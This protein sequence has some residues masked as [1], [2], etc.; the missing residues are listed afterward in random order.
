MTS[1][2]FSPTQPPRIHLSCLVDDQPRFRMHAWNWLVALAALETKV[3]LFIH[4]TPTALSDATKDQFRALGAT[5][6][7][8]LPFDHGP[9]RYCNKIRQLETSEFTDADFVILSDADMIFNNDPAGMVRKDHLRARVVDADNPPRAIWTELFSRAGLSEALARVGNIPLALEPTV[10]TFATNFNGGFYAM[11]G[12]MARALLPL[13]HKYAAFSLSQTDLLGKWLLHSD[14]LGF[15]MAVA[16][17]GFAVDLLPFTANL[18]T[19]LAKQ[20]YAPIAAQDVTA[21]HYH[22]HLDQHGLPLPV[23]VDWIDRLIAKS[24][25]VLNEGRRTGF[26][27]EIFW[28]YRYDQFPELGSGLGSRDAV[29]AHKH[30]LLHP[31]VTMIGTGTILDVGC[32]DL[33]VFGPLPA[34]NYTGIDISEQALMIARSKRPDCE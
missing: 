22:K 2:L 21:L 3:R 20:V 14:Q 12:S 28:D 6:V 25:Q 11:P 16:D 19:H 4:H 15:G 31:F 24:R 26:S 7:E 32:G 34:V 9:A 8:I 29:L 17:A 30:D 13:W 18:P 1:P 27:N 23:G 10:T 5:L 33:E